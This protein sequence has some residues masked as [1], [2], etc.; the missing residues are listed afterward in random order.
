MRRGMSMAV[1][2]LGVTTLAAAPK[3]DVVGLAWLEGTWVGEKDGVEMEE[4]W[5]APRGGALLGVHRDVKD[6]R[7]VSYEFLRIEQTD[8]GIVYFASPRGKPPVP[9]TLVEQSERR[10]VFE[11]REHDF[12]QRILYW[13]DAKGALHAR[14][15]GPRGDRTHSEEWTWTRKR[16]TD[17]A[18]GMAA[19][20]DNASAKRRASDSTLAGEA[21]RMP[22]KAAS[23]PSWRV[24]AGT[25][26]ASNTG[27]PVSSM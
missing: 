15:E 19:S 22:E 27:S 26:S 24:N 20:A 17:S 11:N 21:R 4:H 3:G 1:L 18:R 12:P 23:A 5:T 2:L 10:A 6:G 14:I 7:L 8:A 25:T 16:P 13:L 9:F